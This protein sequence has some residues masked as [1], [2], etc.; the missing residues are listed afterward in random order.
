MS[1]DGGS[2][3]TPAG[4]YPDGQ[5]GQRWWDG[6]QWGPVGQPPPAPDVSPP[7]TPMPT[8]PPPQGPPP[9]GPPPTAQY[10]AYAPPGQAPGGPGGSGSSGSSG[11]STK[12]LLG[13]VGGLVGVAVVVVLLVLVLGGGSGPSS[14]DPAETVASFVDAAR[15]NDCDAASELLTED[16]RTAFAIDECGTTDTTDVFEDTELEVG[17]ASVDGDEA[18]VPVAISDTSADADENVGP[19]EVTVEFLLVR[20]DGAWLID[21][22]SFA[23]LLDDLPE[24]LAPELPS[25]GAPDGAPDELPEFDPEDLLS[26]L[27]DDFLSDLPE[28]FLSDFPSDFL[29]DFDPE[30]FLSDLPEDFLSD[31]PSDFLSDFPTDFDPEDFMSDFPSDFPTDLPSE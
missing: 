12:L 11:P 16:A 10:G 24:D 9:Q 7:T 22:F 28:D 20:T 17:E 4:W 18:A 25:D 13:I 6:T 5:G 26:D 30:D 21:D 31:F 19:D 15:D 1:D 3:G 8:M 14:D 29:S 2:T 27:P 23:S